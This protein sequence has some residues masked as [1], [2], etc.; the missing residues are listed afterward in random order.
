MTSPNGTQAW[1]RPQDA[2]SDALI[3][4]DGGVSLANAGPLV[5]A[6]TDVLVA[7]SFVFSAPAGPVATLASLREHLAGLELHF[8]AA[9]AGRRTARH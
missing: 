4:V 5:E 8:D 7:G 3:E 9:P 6:G 1:L 2:G